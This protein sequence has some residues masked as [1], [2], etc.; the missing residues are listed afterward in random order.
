MRE[1]LARV[2]GDACFDFIKCRPRAALD[3]AVRAVAVT[4]D[5]QGDNVVSGM[6]RDGFRKVLEVDFTAPHAME[7][8]NEFRHVRWSRI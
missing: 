7:E 8:D 3:A 4:F 1:V 5:A 2:C 6:S